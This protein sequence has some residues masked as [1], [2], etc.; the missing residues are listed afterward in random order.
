MQGSGRVALLT[1]HAIRM[2]FITCG[3]SDSA[4]FFKIISKNGTVFGG[5][6]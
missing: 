5:K 2:R 4:T 3:F 1:P 6:K